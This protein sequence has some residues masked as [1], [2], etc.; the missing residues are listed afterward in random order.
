MTC[1][2]VNIELEYYN[3]KT[4]YPSNSYN[5]ISCELC[6]ELIKKFVLYLKNFCITS[7]LEFNKSVFSHN[8]LDRT[9]LNINLNNLI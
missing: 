6:F 2:D 4:F 3:I 8:R 9:L 1:S 5:N 7:S